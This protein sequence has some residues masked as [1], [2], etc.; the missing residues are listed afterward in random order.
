[1]CDLIC[2][3][4]LKL[5][6]PLHRG[7]QILVV[8]GNSNVAVVIHLTLISVTGQT[9]D[10]YTTELYF[11]YLKNVMSFLYMFIILKTTMTFF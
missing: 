8:I 2:N 3:S 1:M 6:L 5:S 7:L 11:G 4:F 9:F 10:P